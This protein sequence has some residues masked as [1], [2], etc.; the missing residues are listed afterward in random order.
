[1]II[2]NKTID[3]NVQKG[4]EC[5]FLDSSKCTI[6]MTTVISFHA[7]RME[8]SSDYEK[9]I[10]KDAPWGWVVTFGA[11]FNTM[12]T[13]GKTTAILLGLRFPAFLRFPSP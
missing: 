1:M 11:M 3:I 12:F 9:R 8:N 13:V 10:R 4:D 7:F 5:F 2:I 6:F